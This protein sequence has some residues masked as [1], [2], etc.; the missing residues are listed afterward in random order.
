MRVRKIG[1]QRLPSRLWAKDDLAFGYSRVQYV[2]TLFVGAVAE[3]KIEIPHSTHPH[4]S[5]HFLVIVNCGGTAKLSLQ[6][7]IIK[8]STTRM[9]ESGAI[10]VCIKYYHHHSLEPDLFDLID[11][12]PFPGF[13]SIGSTRIHSI[14]PKRRLL[15]CCMRQEI[16]E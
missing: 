7:I 2:P 5:S 10:T 13:V 12:I 3:A 11:C 14:G 4:R 1:R 6:P 16:H 8:G 9:R 15:H